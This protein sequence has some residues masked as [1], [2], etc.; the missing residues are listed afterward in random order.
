MFMSFL[1][2]SVKNKKELRPIF[3]LGLIKFCSIK[4]FEAIS[5]LNKFLFENSC[6]N[7]KVLS[8]IDLLGLFTIL[9]KA[10]SSFG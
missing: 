1:H 8:P 9:P 2:L 5:K 3:V 6:I 10:K 4:V 7:L